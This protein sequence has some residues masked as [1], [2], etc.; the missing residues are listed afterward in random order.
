MKTRAMHVVATAILFA[1]AAG[2]AWGQATLTKVEGTV[3]DGNKPV[4]DVQ[5]VLTYQDTGRVFKI[6]TDKGG[7]FSLVGLPR[8]V[9]TVEVQSA[10]GEN[11]FRE[12]NREIK[13]EAGVAGGSMG[14]VEKM[15]LD[16]AGQGGAQPKV[17]KEEVER[18][19]AE[20]AKATSLNALIGQY[21]AAQASQNWKEAE[22]ILKQMVAADPNNWRFYQ[23]LGTTQMNLAEFEDAI[24]SYDKGIQLAQAIVSG[25]APKDP[26][27]PDSDP[28]KAKAGVGQMLASQ[29]N[30]YLKLK[31]NP[32]AIA[33]FTK[34]AEMDP[35]PGVAYFNLCATQ[36]N[37]GNTEGALAACDKAIA[38]DPNKA[39]AYFIKGSLLM[40]AGKLDAQGKY[41]PPAGTAQ[42]LNKYLELAPDG[43]HAVDVK[44]MLEAI[45]A[46]IETSYGKKKK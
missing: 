29:G 19:K 37:T 36:Y 11:L 6:K 23:A 35:N 38:A 28:A 7:A 5:V 33:S 17:T 18:I 22:P 40:G 45:G 20:N 9:Y 26:R 43:P 39:D 41:V 24:G 8:G 44:Q 34:A 12:K 30:A 31:K 32:E 14:G 46:K 15:N 10:S 27:N 1:C 3:K 2:A 4:A 25:T 42:A 16:I 13:G 21:N